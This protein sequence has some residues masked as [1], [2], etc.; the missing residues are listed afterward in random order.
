M[1]GVQ[2]VGFGVFLYVDP[3]VYNRDQVRVGDEVQHVAGYRPV[4]AAE[5]QVAV[6]RLLVGLF[7]MD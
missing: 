7:L 2:P 4:D 6:Q 5:Y 3:A 1:G